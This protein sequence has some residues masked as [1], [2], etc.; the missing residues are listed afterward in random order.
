MKASQK[1]MGNS[2]A[3]KGGEGHSRQKEWNVQKV[4]SCEVGHVGGKCMLA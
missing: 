1:D 3:D 2:Q 4:K